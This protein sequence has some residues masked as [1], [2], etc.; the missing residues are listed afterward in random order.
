M[1]GDVETGTFI[2]T[3]TGLNHRALPNVGGNNTNMHYPDAVSTAT[4][5]YRAINETSGILTLT[6]VAIDDLTIT[7]GVNPAGNFSHLQMFE[8]DSNGFD[9]LVVEIDISFTSN[10][11][12]VTSD[13]ITLRQPTSALVNTFD[14]VRTPST[15]LL[16]TG[17]GVPVNY[18]PTID[19]NRPSKIALASLGNRLFRFTNGIPNPALNFTIQFTSQS[20][21]AGTETGTGLLRLAGAPVDDA[22]NYTYTRINGT[23]NATLVISSANGASTTLNG[24][25]TIGYAGTDSGIYTGSADADT[26]NPADV[27]GT[28]FIPANP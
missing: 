24:S 12:T 19:P 28:F 7:G 11:T 25:Y 5:S 26:V 13:T 20:T 23:D 14:T 16:A 2:Y 3:L 15:V 22:V 17:G 18:N 21:N 10:G 8:A 6:G 27:S 1:S 9:A 4:Y